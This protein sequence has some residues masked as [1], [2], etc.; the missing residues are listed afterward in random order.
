MN[1]KVY[2][3]GISRVMFFQGGKLNLNSLS[4]AEKRDAVGNLSYLCC[5]GGCILPCPSLRVRD[6]LNINCENH[7]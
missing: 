3:M 4:L 1:F 5:R 6:E 2:S 7:W